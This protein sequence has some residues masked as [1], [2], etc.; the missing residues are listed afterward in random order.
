MQAVS[1]TANATGSSTPRSQA[2]ASPAQSSTVQQ[3]QAANEVRPCC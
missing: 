3:L 2:G 1:V